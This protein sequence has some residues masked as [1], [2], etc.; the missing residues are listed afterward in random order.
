MC[1]TCKHTYN[2]YKDRITNKSIEELA[3]FAGVV[4]VGPL[5]LPT[6]TLRTPAKEAIEEL[7]LL[8]AA[9]AIIMS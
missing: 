9:C 1:N 7:N 5:S 8:N 4:S 3:S 2:T 6:P